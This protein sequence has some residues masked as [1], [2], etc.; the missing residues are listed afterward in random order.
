MVANEQRTDAA[1]YQEIVIRMREGADYYSAAADTH[2]DFGYP[3]APFYTVRPPTL[4]TAH[5]LFGSA[6]PWIALGLILCTALA[7]Y[8]RV[9][10]RPLPAR[11]LAPLLI[12]FFGSNGLF[13]VAIHAHDWWAG[14]FLSLALAL[15]GRWPAMLGAALVAALF[16]DLAVPMLLL[17]PLVHR[18]R[19][20]VIATAIA[21]LVVAAFYGFHAY[22]VWEV[23]LPTDERSPGWL[24]MRGPLAFFQDIAQ[25]T[26]LERLGP[27]GLVF[28]AIPAIGWIFA[29]DWLC[30][31][32]FAGVAL[33]AATIAR[34]D[35]FYWAQLALPA[36]LVGLAFLPWPR[37]WRFR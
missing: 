11:L 18:S 13:G 19:R 16:R 33:A 25:L 15:Q 23:T 37:R 17:I 6:M 30:L 22:S 4:A 26:D 9:E 3:L 7:W 14:L 36:Y 35:N 24:A 2:R 1:V 27:F 29:R 10:H 20:V 34:P 28:A 31:A 8:L 5:A 12:A 21:L 32:W